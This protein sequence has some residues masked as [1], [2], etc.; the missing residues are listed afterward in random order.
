MAILK[1]M[2]KKPKSRKAQYNVFAYV[3]RKAE[4]TFGIG[5]SED[6]YQSNRDF[7]TIQLLSDTLN[8][9]NS[10]YAQHWCLSFERE[11]NSAEKT[12]E[13]A[14][15]FVEKALQDK[16][17]QVFIA[18]HTDQENSIHAHLVLNNVN[19]HGKKLQT[20][21]RELDKFK[22]I[23]NEIAREFGM[24]VLDLDTGKEKTQEKGKKRSVWQK[25][26]YFRQEQLQKL[27]NAI[28][29]EVV[30][31]GDKN[32]DYNLE[33]II[34][35][36]YSKMDDLRYKKVMDKAVE[37]LKKDQLFNI[38]MDNLYATHVMIAT[39][40]Q[41]ILEMPQEYED[42]SD[43]FEEVELQNQEI[44]KQEQ[45]RQTEL[46]RQREEQVRQT[47]NAWSSRTS[48][49]NSWNTSKSEEQEEKSTG[50][51]SRSS[52]DLWE[53]I[54]NK[55]AEVPAQTPGKKGQIPKIKKKPKTKNRGLSR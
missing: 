55:Q 35:E 11:N 3:G 54:T 19:Y 47:A 8:R 24:K 14:K 18:V 43:E 9:K 40:E 6:W 49:G 50:W 4:L 46:Q 25:Q 23:Q 5:C 28:Y 20:T 39:E 7:Q 29:K 17:I 36:Q 32:L 2:G 21:K 52:A 27:K 41:Q 42:V 45:Q 15:Q 34:Q 37:S 12:L 16:D 30:K 22:R 26:N 1:V 53:E 10:R 44:K 13:M 51:G 48:R 33:Q 31:I 38:E